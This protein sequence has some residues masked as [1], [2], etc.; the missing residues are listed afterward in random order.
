MEPLSAQVLEVVAEE[1]APLL[2]YEDLLSGAVCEISQADRLSAQEEAAENERRAEE[3][4]AEVTCN[5]KSTRS[6]VN[7]IC[8]DLLV[9]TTASVIWSPISTALASIYDDRGGLVQ[10]TAT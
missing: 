10:C 8:A 1:T 4:R 7:Q 6:N 5:A 9:G 2:S 3:A